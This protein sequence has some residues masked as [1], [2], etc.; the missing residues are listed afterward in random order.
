M[1]QERIRVVVGE[2]HPS[3]KGVLRFVLEGEGH[4]VVAEAADGTEVA[5]V[6]AAERPDV[7]VLDDGIGVTA[8]QAA[9][10]ASSATKVILVW[11]S[12][13]MPIGGDARVDPDEILRDLGPAVRRVLG[14]PAGGLETF[15]RP[16]WVDRIRKDPATLR[17]LLDRRGGLPTRPSVTELQRATA[18]SPPA[19]ARPAETV[20]PLVILPDASSDDEPVVVVDAPAA[21]GEP[22][23]SADGR[24]NDERER[25]AAVVAFPTTG[26]AAASADPMATEWNSRLGTL[27]LG[28]AAVIGALVIAL[29]IGTPRV[30]TD[31]VAAE[32][33]SPSIAPPS[34]GDDEPGDDGG[35][36]GPGHDG[37]DG[38]GGD[39]GGNGGG[40]RPDRGIDGA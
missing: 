21:Q 5:R 35:T 22:A 4:D 31:V 14:R 32:R 12:A 30:P 3:R 1:A 7:V 10:D 39:G 17:E 8:V 16:E 37:G 25:D 9:R 13:V 11:P 38:G 34:P 23:A 29:G 28:G 19:S 26:A 20:A 15:R 6:V 40:V 27:A 2:G 18:S 36:T 24:P 33:P